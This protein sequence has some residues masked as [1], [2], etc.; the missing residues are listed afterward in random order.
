M[1]D[2]ACDV[3]IIGAG[4]AGCIAAIALAPSCRV[5]LLDRQNEP[6]ARI[7]ECLPAAGRRILEPL[8]L[9]GE[10]T[11]PDSPHRRALGMQSYWGSPRCQ[12]NDDLRN[13]DGFGFHLDRP[14]FEGF[15]RDQAVAAGATF[16]RPVRFQKAESDGETVDLQ[17]YDEGEGREQKVRAGYVIDAGGRAAPFAKHQTGARIHLDRLTA[18]WATIPNTDA[19][20]MGT[21]QAAE[22]GWWYSA[23]LPNGRRVLAY[24]SDSDL[25]DSALHRDAD[26]FLTKAGREPV[27]AQW[28]NPQKPELFLH[29]IVPAGSSRLPQPAGRL[30][31]AVGDAACAFD[32]LSSQGMFHAM[33][34]AM[35]LCDLLKATQ[36]LKNG[37]VSSRATVQKTYTD[38]IEQIWQRYC[39]HRLLF[40]GLEQRFTTS[41]FWQRRHGARYGT[42]MV[43]K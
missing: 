27:L 23:P 26:R 34:T 11:R 29:G 18:C 3:A 22:N 31:A 24:Q 35:Q 21:I 7:G 8:G 37:G 42:E 17:L 36:Q 14:A 19:R 41:P 5:L 10:L 13:P 2:F 32:P 20:A 4:V 38:Q 33:A 28:I 1:T 6:P 9:F 25:I 30:W 40:Y 43:C 15:L 39:S 16:W 12:I